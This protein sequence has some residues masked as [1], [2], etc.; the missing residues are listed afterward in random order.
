MGCWMMLALP[1]VLLPY[2]S[3]LLA[4]GIYYFNNNSCLDSTRT[5]KRVWKTFVAAL[6][7]DT[8]LSSDSGDSI[9]G[10]AG[11]GKRSLEGWAQCVGLSG[12]HA[13]PPHPVLPPL[14]HLLIAA[15]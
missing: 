13:S 6:F 2:C 1:F 14:P 8:T 5:I 10:S 3:N 4:M 15:T 12:L 9:A 11:L 7:L